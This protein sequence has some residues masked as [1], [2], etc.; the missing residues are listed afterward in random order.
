MLYVVG[1]VTERTQD[2]HP[3]KIE[4]DPDAFNS[5]FGEYHKALQMAHRLRAQSDD[6]IVITTDKAM[7]RVTAEKPELEIKWSSAD[8]TRTRTYMERTSDEWKESDGIDDLRIAA[9]SDKPSV[10]FDIDGTLGYW[11]ADG[12]G[13]SSL[14]EII[15]PANHY[16]RDIE[17]HP[18]MIQLARELHEEGFDVCIVS[19]ADRDTIR[20]K[21]EWIQKNLPFIPEENVFFAPLGADKTQFIKGNADISVLIDDYKVN[22]EQWHGKAVKAINTVNSHQDK[23][24]EIDMTVPESSLRRI[25]D[26]EQMLD[27]GMI[28]EQEFER[29][30]DN[31][32]QSFAN[33]LKRAVETVSHEL[34]KRV[35]E[36]VSEMDNEKDALETYIAEATELLLKDEQRGNLINNIVL[37]DEVHA[38]ASE[39]TEHYTHEEVAA[40]LED[41]VSAKKLSEELME[42]LSSFGV[43]P[44][45]FGFPEGDAIALVRATEAISKE[46]AERERSKEIEESMSQTEYMHA[47]GVI[48]VEPYHRDA[49]DR[50]ESADGFNIHTSDESVVRL[51]TKEDGKDVIPRIFCQT[52]GSE[53]EARAAEFGYGGRQKEAESAVGEALS[54]LSELPPAYSGEEVQAWAK[55]TLDVANDMIHKFEEVFYGKP[56]KVETAI[57][58]I[59][60][61]AMAYAY[62]NNAENMSEVEAYMTNSDIIRGGGTN[63]YAYA[64]EIVNAAEVQRQH[65]QGVMKLQNYYDT[66]IAP[67]RAEVLKTG[68]DSHDYWDKLTPEQQEAVSFYSDWHKEYFHH[69][70]DTFAEFPDRDECFAFAI[71]RDAMRDEAMETDITAQIIELQEP[72]LSADNTRVEFYA[73]VYDSAIENLWARTAFYEKTPD[74]KTADEVIESDDGCIN[75]YVS[76][77]K[78]GKA[79]MTAVLDGQIEADVPLTEAEQ[80]QLAEIADKAIEMDSATRSNSVSELIAEYSDEQEI[81]DAGIHFSSQSITF[82]DEIKDSQDM[83]NDD[84]TSKHFKLYVGDD[85]ESGRGVFVDV[86]GYADR[87]GD[88]IIEFD[89]SLDGRKEGYTLDDEM[90]ERYYALPDEVVDM[91]T[92]AARPLI[93]NEIAKDILK[94]EVADYPNGYEMYFAYD[95][96]IDSN[97]FAEIVHAYM[98]ELENGGTSDYPD[99]EAYLSDKIHEQWNLWER[100]T[101]TIESNFKYHHTAAETA[102]VES[103]LKATDQSLPEALGDAGF[104]GVM[105]NVRD[106]VG[107]YKVNIMLATPAEQNHDMGA[108]PDM[109]SQGDIAYLNRI[110]QR[111]TPDERT[112][113]FDN[114][115]TYLI[116]QQG[117]T[118]SEVA[119]SL[120]AGK[121]TDNSFVKSVVSELQEY[122][123][124]SMGELT[125]LVKLDKDSLSV[126]DA[127]AKNGEQELTL[128][129]N[130]R[131]GI[132]NEWSGAG[133]E[134]DIQLEKPL[135]FPADMVRNVQVEMRRAGEYLHGWTVNETY[136]LVG[137]EWKGE[138]AVSSEPSRAAEIT[139]AYMADVPK[140]ADQIKALDKPEKKKQQER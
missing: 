110:L 84:G 123:D 37:F 82:F 66:T 15:D 10:Y 58:E 140:V 99:F 7:E 67:I 45:Y 27:D 118:L 5:H 120:L 63:L 57:G 62:P 56:I 55:E 61:E 39:K 35:E 14:E 134:L 126:I 106:V 52:L 87:S 81:G 103:Y 69:R 12:R 48:K 75:V 119:D 138:L 114:A 31:T 72:E 90:H 89:D 136:G 131:I 21:A 65:E 95:E 73:A 117:H 96:K 86:S 43:D 79:T 92:E 109:F 18:F 129:T 98:E 36:K 88:I 54:I 68:G 107:E 77:D 111:M 42:K 22:L 40:M 128:S 122:P 102:I 64:A 78:D 30:R 4:H 44:A 115:L 83:T 101:D 38:N 127:V 28:P 59:T 16:F 133:S 139:K 50:I 47:Q 112:D 121:E 46:L 49:D 33:Q 32:L 70:P 8:S 91:V 113:H 34:F 2:G 51:I 94:Q 3:S 76:I 24:P 1:T 6:E 17:P 100:E 105:F 29:I 124:Y 41:S 137:S 11:Y 104:E 125:A 130:T 71:N 74:Y 116:Y 108:I 25:R 93:T 80:K 26:A 97:T 53:A 20:D 13:Y 60:V 23:Y 9:H 85:K 135:S 19:A 132:F